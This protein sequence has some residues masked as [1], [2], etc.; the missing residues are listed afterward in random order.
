MPPI[1]RRPGRAAVLLLALVALSVVTLIQVVG[2]ILAIALLT[3]PAE[4]A[5][6]WS[7][8]L[9]QMMV[10]AGIIGAT[11][12]TLGILASYALSARFDISIPSGPLVILMSI[13]VYG[14]SMGANTLRTGAAITTP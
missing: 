13:V 5:R 2:I 11:C 3:V 12:T 4:A 1:L 10:L 9:R 14:L 8:S 7:R 6:P